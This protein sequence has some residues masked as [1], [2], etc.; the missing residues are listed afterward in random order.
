MDL[1]AG[2]LDFYMN[3]GTLSPV[4]RPIMRFG[5]FGRSASRLQAKA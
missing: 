4:F 2:S 3:I 5:L 1:P